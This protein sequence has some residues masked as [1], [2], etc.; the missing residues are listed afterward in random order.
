MELGEDINKKTEVV[1]NTSD[2]KL[3]TSNFNNPIHK[4]NSSNLIY[5]GWS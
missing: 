4:K 1:I 3:R 2:S 5:Y